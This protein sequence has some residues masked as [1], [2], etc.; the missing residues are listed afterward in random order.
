MEIR[1]RLRCIG[2][3]MMIA[4]PSQVVDDL[5]LKAGDYVLVDVKDSTILV[6]EVGKSN[7]GELYVGL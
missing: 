1:R 5:K 7:D 6:R 2:N 3:S 4:I